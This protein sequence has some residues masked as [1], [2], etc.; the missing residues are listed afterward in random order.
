MSQETIIQTKVLMDKII[1][2]SESSGGL[3]YR[4]GLRNEV[5]NDNTMIHVPSFKEFH[6]N[7]N[8]SSIKGVCKKKSW[9]EDDFFKHFMKVIHDEVYLRN[10]VAIQIYRNKSK[11]YI[12]KF[13][14]YEFYLYKAFKREKENKNIFSAIEEYEYK[15]PNLVRRPDITFWVNGIFFSLLEL[16]HVIQ[17]QYA[18]D[19][20]YKIVQDFSD[21]ISSERDTYN[22]RAR[23][24]SNIGLKGFTKIFTAGIFVVATDGLDTYVSRRLRFHEKKLHIAK[25]NN[26]ELKERESVIKTFEKID[27]F[28]KNNSF[29]NLKK[30]LHFFYSKGHV[31]SEISTF[32]F[33]SYKL[34]KDAKP[35]DKTKHMTVPRY[36]QVYGSRK[37]MNDLKD[38]IAHEDNINY[39]I[40]KEAER[41][42]KQDF[43]SD[44]EFETALGKR[45][46]YSNDQNTDSYLLQY[47]A[48]FGKTIT[49]LALAQSLW[50]IT[51]GESALYEDCNHN[52]LYQKI[53][54]AVDR[55]DLAEQT[56]KN[57]L[58]CN[59][60]HNSVALISET[61]TDTE[62]SR[63]EKALLDSKKTF[64]ILTTQ[65]F[66]KSSIEKLSKKAKNHLKEMRYAILIDEVHRTQNGELN[67]QMMGSLMD[68]SNDKEHNERNLVVGFTATPKE[69]TLQKYGHFVKVGMNGPQWIPFDNFTLKQAIAEGFVLDPMSNMVAITTTLE[70]LG[71][72]N[73]N[74]R[75]PSGADIHENI[76]FI[77]ANC[78]HFVR[79]MKNHTFEN[80][81][82]TA[83]A[84][85]VAPSIISSIKY[86]EGL[87]SSGMNPE[88]TYIVFSGDNKKQGVPSLKSL[89]PQV[90]KAGETK[91]IVN[92]FLADNKAVMIVVDM[93]QTG[94]DDP[95]LHTLFLAKNVSGI[96]AVQVGCRINRSHPSKKD[97]LIIDAT[98]KNFNKKSFNEAFKKYEGVVSGEMDESEKIVRLKKLGNSLRKDSIYKR[99][100]TETKV[101]VDKDGEI[102][103]FHLIDDI[104][105]DI[106]ASEEIVKNYINMANEYLSHYDN[107][108][109]VIED[110]KED[111]YFKGLVGFRN[112]LSRVLKATIEKKDSLDFNLDSSEIEPDGL[113]KLFTND[114]D[115]N[116]KRNKNGKQTKQTT[117]LAQ[118]IKNENEI[119][120]SV[121]DL[122][123]EFKDVCYFIFGEI[124]N[125]HGMSKEKWKNLDRI[126]DNN[127]KFKK[128]FRKYLKRQK[129]LR[130]KEIWVEGHDNDYILEERWFEFTE[131]LN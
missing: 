92:A 68:V 88:K 56:Y 128:I 51:K 9:S 34:G 21:S 59:I 113:H 57:M 40:E 118:R 4:R 130:F 131:H 111:F 70:I 73:D 71:D 104:R 82:N 30:T 77:N 33:G 85:L 22:S 58:N 98:Y 28:D 60:S 95:R 6:L 55:S 17:N 1:L 93:L 97:C 94:F 62:S 13:E 36:K 84:M 12:L 80:I 50:R 74:N 96:P 112:I 117:N 19:G 14:G 76:D 116:N 66:S 10:N 78:K 105:N 38:R 3:G 67:E 2:A 107:L 42:K 25:S 127:K 29:N 47:S 11:P 72:V 122:I 123:S 106:K 89:N 121:D 120:Q 45:K 124:E 54:I 99:F 83:K 129:D 35:N 39:V 81:G 44:D 75:L 16:K 53:I 108:A 5:S 7:I 115:G 27:I 90:E 69:E 79:I 101:C 119:N 24:D 125:K 31:Q 61:K 20:V 91:N 87:I 114:Q 64:V 46:L 48:G 110:V 41:L 65:S 63:L 86:R 23:I 37:I 8:Q 52:L 109:G 126:E 103:D 43:I 32:N 102:N 26:S 15:L 100:F 18:I 49:M